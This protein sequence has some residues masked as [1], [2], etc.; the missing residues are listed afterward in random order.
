MDVMRADRLKQVMQD[1][2]NSFD[3]KDLG[4]SKFSRFVGEAAQRGV[5]K[6][7]KLDN[8]QLEVDVPD[9]VQAVAPAA[10][11]EPERHD[12]AAAAPATS[13]RGGGGRGRGGRGGRGGPD[14]R[15]PATVEAVP[16]P[17]TATVPVMPST[18]PASVSETGERLTRAEALDLLRRAMDAL[19]PV[20]ASAV[21]AGVVREKARALLGRDSETLSEKFFTRILQDAHDADVID[22]RRRG[23]DFEVARVVATTPIADQLRQPAAAATPAVAGQPPAR[24]QSRSGRAAFGKKLGAAPPELLAVGVVSLAGKAAGDGQRAAVAAQEGTATQDPEAAR[25]ETESD[26]PSRKKRRGKRA[27]AA[28]AAAPTAHGDSSEPGAD[29]KPAPRKRAARKTSAKKGA[30]AAT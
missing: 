25:Q 14:R 11:A 1:I 13:R 3:E 15:T 30:A 4:M 28:A 18:L 2:D 16:A 21:P 9:E 6:V 12:V 10:E 17:V 19:A 7:S 22:L 5:L 26:E 27:K 24:T 23:D 29:E 20:G 8:G